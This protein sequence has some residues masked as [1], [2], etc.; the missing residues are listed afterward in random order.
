M[1]WSLLVAALVAHAATARA[2][3]STDRARRHFDLGSS[4]FDAGRYE[5][6]IH[7]FES[8]QAIKPRPRFFYNVARCYEHLEDWRRAVDNYRRYLAADPNAPEGDD[9]RIRIRTLA[10]RAQQGGNRPPPRPEP[11]PDDGGFDRA[12]ASTPE[13]RATR[14]RLTAIAASA[15]TL[16]LGVAGALL[17]GTSLGDYSRLT[18]ICA[19]RPCTPSD[20][21]DAK[22]RYYAGW[23]LVG[24]FAAAA[25]I[26]VALWVMALRAPRAPATASLARFASGV[27]F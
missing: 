16:T 25:A 1:R 26:D 21:S 22:T 5:E 3:P 11:L 18:T 23:A 9:L 24:L 4:Y 14:L 15:G 2:D 13:G 20:W 8:A 7:E 19:L 12:E 17:V 6:A 10:D 27:R